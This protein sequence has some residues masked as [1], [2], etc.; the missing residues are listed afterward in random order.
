MSMTAWSKFAGAFGIPMKPAVTYAEGIGRDVAATEVP[1]DAE[2]GEVAGA[3][4]EQAVAAS[5]A[6]PARRTRMH[7]IITLWRNILRREPESP[8]REHIVGG[9]GYEVDHT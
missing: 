9:T 4:D 5:V 7:R 6:R 8:G 1:G 3:A 2:G